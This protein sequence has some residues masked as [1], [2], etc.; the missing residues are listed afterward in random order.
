MS[1]LDTA[2]HCV[3]ETKEIFLSGYS[4]KKNITHKGMFD[5][6]T[7]VDKEIEDKVVQ[8]I[9]SDY[10][11]HDILAEESHVTERRSKHRWIIDPLDG[12]TNFVH[13][14]P[15]FSISIALEEEGEI[16]L[17]VVYQPI[18]G[19]LF[20]AEKGKGAYLNNSKIHVSDVTSLS[21]SILA[22]GFPYDKYQYADLYSSELKLFLE[23][24]QGIRR[25]GV[26]SLDLCFLSCGRFD[27]FW[28][29]KLKPWDVAASILIIK[30][31]GG[32]ITNFSGSPYSF[33]DNTIMASNSLI[34]KE[35]LSTIN[36]N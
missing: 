3:E 26:A 17:G 32:M 10:P 9:Q 24:V 16:I 31:A 14:V 29:R 2:I 7:T 8:I 36:T 4:Q 33:Q 35:M 5:L 1:Y 20:L 19:E 6:V 28:E 22:T 21:N 11:N 25:F 23:K 12:T 34:H 13:S 27:G 30:E 18:S 15:H